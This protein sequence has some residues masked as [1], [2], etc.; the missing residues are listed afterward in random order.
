MMQDLLTRKERVVMLTHRQMTR[1][2]IDVVTHDMASLRELPHCLWRA[3]DGTR[4]REARYQ[5]T[6]RFLVP[7]QKVFRDNVG[8]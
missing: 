2:H 8:G 1:Q 3:S 5:R 4:S 6:A 7:C